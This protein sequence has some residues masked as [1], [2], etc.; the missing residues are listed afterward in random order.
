M[1]NR[2]L[3]NRSSSLAKVVPDL[4]EDL[5]EE[6][7]NYWLMRFIME[8]NRK[9]GSPYPAVTLKHLCVG[10]QRYFRDVVG[11]PEINLFDGINFASFRKTLDSKMKDLN[12]KGIHLHKKQAQPLTLEDEHTLWEKGV[13]ASDTAHGL[14]NA[15]Y[16]Y[17][18][19][20]FGLRAADEHSNLNVD[21]FTV[22]KN[23]TGEYVRYK[24]KVCKNN[25]GGLSTTGRVQFKDITQYGQVDNDRC[26]VKLMKIYLDSIPKE[27]PFIEG[28]WLP[29]I[30]ES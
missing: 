30:V 14:F 2:N 27:G 28:P 20:I 1:T 10:L 11:R 26:Y 29:G 12:R 18:S 16:F 23:D 22:G 21:Q 8:V 19:K 3:Y 17:T 9:D 4:T 6:R 24:G 25:Q 5:S 15:I 13:F 7:I